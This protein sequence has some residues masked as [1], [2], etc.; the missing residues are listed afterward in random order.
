MNTHSDDILRSL[1][2]FTAHRHLGDTN[3]WCKMTVFE[4]GTRNTLM[5][6]VP[7][8]KASSQGLNTRLVEMVDWVSEHSCLKIDTM[9]GLYVYF[10]RTGPPL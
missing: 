2:R 4:T 8:Q 1:A 5:W 3:S 7:G 10:V 6:R 9:S